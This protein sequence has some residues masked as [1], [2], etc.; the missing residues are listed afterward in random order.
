M[1]EFEAAPKALKM[2]VAF[3]D[4]KDRAAFAKLLGIEVTDSTLKPIP[5]RICIII[6]EC[7][8][9][10]ISVFCCEISLLRRP[11]RS[12]RN[13]SNPIDRIDHIIPIVW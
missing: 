7:K 8:N 9:L 13:Y 4:E 5:I 6:Q 3:R 1:P 2:I 12:R 11:Y 10:T